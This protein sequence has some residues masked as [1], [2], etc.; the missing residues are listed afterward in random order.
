MGIQLT[1][2]QQ[3]ALDTQEDSPPRVIDGYVIKSDCKPFRFGLTNPLHLSAD[4]R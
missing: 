3:Q 2:Q 1:P 4:R